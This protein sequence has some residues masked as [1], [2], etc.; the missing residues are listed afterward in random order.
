MS[1][2]ARADIA[3]AKFLEHTDG[4]AASFFEAC[5]HCGECAD[6]CQFYLSTGDPKYTP[7][8]KLQ[9]MIRA[10]KRDK[11]PFSTLKRWLD[12]PPRK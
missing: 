6:A 10:Y 3:V 1:D 11:A 4:E 7:I 5:V 8:N 2:Q 9:P 12:W